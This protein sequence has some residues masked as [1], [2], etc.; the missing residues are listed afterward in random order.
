MDCT[1]VV[2]VSEENMPVIEQTARD[3]KATWDIEFMG[4]EP[5]LKVDVSGEGVK[6]VTAASEEKT[7]SIISY[8]YLMPYG[9]QGY[10]RRLAGLV[11]TSINPGV[12]V[13]SDG[14]LKIQAL[15]RSSVDSKK[16]ELAGQV[17]TLADLCGAGY[18]SCNDYPGW[19]YR[20][21]SPLRDIMVDTYKEMYGAEP[22][23]MTIHAGLECGLFLGKRPDLDC[24]SFGP[25][26]LDVHSCR[27]RLNIASVE[28]CYDYLKAVLAKCR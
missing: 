8:L 18:S 12:A 5:S 21:D 7:D 14:I 20:E 3:M 9:P 23:V 24:V 27:E 19:M 28:R 17:H 4:D 15:L 2:L 10:S 26:V 22:E 1:A 13:T 11:E 25:D 6:E 16:E